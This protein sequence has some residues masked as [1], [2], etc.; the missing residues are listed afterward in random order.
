MV[1]K[2]MIARLAVFATICMGAQANSPEDLNG[3]E[4]AHVAYT[5]DSIDIRYAHLALAISKD[6]AIHA[7]AKTMIRDHSAVNRKAL[8]LM[9]KLNVSPQDNFLSRSLVWRNTDIVPHT[10]SAKDGSWD[11][12]LIAARGQWEAR[13]SADTA[14]DYYCRFHP[15]MLAVLAYPTRQGPNRGRS[16]PSSSQTQ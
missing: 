7:F 4:I 13:V 3:P 15:T 1:D 6:P 10:A 12:G 2:M 9:N 11:S 8:A 5:A 16:D 14:R